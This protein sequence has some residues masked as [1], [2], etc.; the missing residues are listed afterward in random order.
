[1]LISL[2]QIKRSPAGSYHLESVYG[3]PKHVVMLRED[4]TTKRALN[5]GKIDLPINVSAEFTK[6]VIHAET[7]TEITVIGSPQ[8][9]ESKFFQKNKML[10]KD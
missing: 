4:Q 6:L 2:V 3:N 7:T 1:M 9:I 10:L 5:E 8:I